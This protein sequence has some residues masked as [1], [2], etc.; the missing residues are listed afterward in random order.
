MSIL[1]KVVTAVFGKKSDKDLK[2]LNPF[3][4]KINA[5]FNT[6]SDITDKELQNRFLSI[7]N[8]FKNIEDQF[9][10]SYK[11]SNKVVAQGPLK[12]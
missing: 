7:R 3:I 8:E 4:D 10:D 2:R 11:E 12:N 9:K 1:S 5:E 6:L